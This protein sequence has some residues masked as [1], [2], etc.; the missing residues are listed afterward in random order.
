MSIQNK[1]CDKY[2]PMKAII[3]KTSCTLI[4]SVLV[5]I[6]MQA[7]DIMRI[8]LKDGSSVEYPISQIRKLTFSGVTAVS[9]GQLEML[10]QAIIQLKAYPN[11]AR[12]NIKIDYELTG[13]GPVVVGIFTMNGKK[14]FEE[15]IGK[16]TPGKHTYVWSASQYPSGQYIIRIQQ[17]QQVALKK[18]IINK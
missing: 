2:L 4:I 5:C 15:N 6:S 8:S 11:P 7:Q 12:N 13:K 1:S 9:P 17:N 18:L 14:V 10:Q 3:F 16:N